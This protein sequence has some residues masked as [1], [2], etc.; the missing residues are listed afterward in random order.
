M[1]GRQGETDEEAHCSSLAGGR[2]NKQGN[3]CERLVLGGCKI[4]RS[5]HLPTGVLKVYVEA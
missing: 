3:L 5:S 4:S 1:N 2:F